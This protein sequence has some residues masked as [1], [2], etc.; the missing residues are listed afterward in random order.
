M[1]QSLAERLKSSDKF[2][3]PDAAL[4]LDKV[5]EARAVISTLSLAAMAEMDL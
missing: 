4:L 5:A 3:P 2:G 1:H